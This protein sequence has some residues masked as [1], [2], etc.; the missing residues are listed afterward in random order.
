VL[1][2]D[3]DILEYCEPKE[4]IIREQHYLNL[5]SPEYNILKVAGSNLGRFFFITLQS[6]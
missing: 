3:A 6:N 1:G 2:C 5:Y 4:L